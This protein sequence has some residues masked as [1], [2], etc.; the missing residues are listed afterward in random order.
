MPPIRWV[1]KIR[2]ERIKA[3]PQRKESLKT[4]S[5]VQNAVRANLAS[6]KKNQRFNPT[7]SKQ[8]IH[9]ANTLQRIANHHKNTL[10]KQRAPLKTIIKA[11]ARTKRKEK[12][13]LLKNAPGRKVSLRAIRDKQ[14][15]ANASKYISKTTRISLLKSHH[16]AEAE[17]QQRYVDDTKKVLK[18]L[19]KTI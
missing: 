18:E 17:R 3:S 11:R 4:I 16:M 19:R 5:A 15:E 8:E 6:A 12:L 1:R 9:L 14:R 13:I 10:R 2:A 7:L